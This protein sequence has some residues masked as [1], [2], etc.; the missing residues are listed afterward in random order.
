MNKILLSPTHHTNVLSAG[1]T[2]A[3]WID[4]PG[5][6]VPAHM[7][8][9]D[10]Q[11]YEVAPKER[12]NTSGVNRIR[13]IEQVTSDSIVDCESDRTCLLLWSVQTGSGTSD[14]E[15]DSTHTEE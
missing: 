11:K 9:V 4:E 10:P 15:C 3:I 2:V 14:A 5:W 1:S 8:S 12:P 7:N 6:M 13:H